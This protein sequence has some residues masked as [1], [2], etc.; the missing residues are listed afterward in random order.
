MVREGRRQDGLGPPCAVQGLG[1]GEELEV[2]VETGWGEPDTKA[3]GG[4][5]GYKGQGEVIRMGG[6]GS[7]TADWALSLW[8][9]LYGTQTLDAARG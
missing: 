8:G 1:W 2:G 3:P 9:K 4:W 7:G 5:R 6:A